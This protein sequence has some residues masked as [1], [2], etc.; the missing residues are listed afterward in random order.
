MGQIWAA[1]HLLLRRRVAV[2]FLSDPL[3]DSLEALQRFSLEAQ[4]IARLASPHVPQVFDYG[5][6]DDGTPFMVMEL[7]QGV[8]L[9]SRLAGDLLSIE[10][11]G[12]MLTQIGSVLS[13]AH[14]IGI[15]HRDIKPENIFL[16]SE[17][18]T[19]TVKLLDFGIAKASTKLDEPVTLHGVTMGTP[20]YMSPEQLLGSRD[21]DGRSDLWS[22]AVVAYNALTG[23]LPFPG[24]TFGAFC[25]AV[26]AGAFAAPSTLRPDLPP[27]LD[28]WFRK[29]LRRSPHDR[30]ASADE[31]VAA[32][33]AA[34]TAAPEA[35]ADAGEGVVPP[36][37]DEPRDAVL[38][39][40]SEVD[41]P[42]PP[43]APAGRSGHGRRGLGLVVTL[44]VIGSAIAFGTGSV[45][46]ALSGPVQSVEVDV[47]RFKA[48]GVSISEALAGD[49][50]R[51]GGAA[52]AAASSVEAPPVQAA[53]AS[54]EAWLSAQ[55]AD[56][57]PS[58]STHEGR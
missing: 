27:A 5:N 49:L 35:T 15:V 40:G 13:A 1:E 10:E 58:K 26:Q 33:S 50:A 44:L 51:A 42:I 23:A 43:M 22:L 28:G 36:R 19:F 31:M 45:P 54:A 48:A 30:F 16:V 29:A 38:S 6:M 12:R 9:Q 39:R 2:K 41:L 47:A 17:E 53:A 4:T 11:T 14:A 18:A 24:D 55:R 37:P 25:F 3:A 8:D 57:A 56:G 32:F 21:L 7:L 34:V 52:P 20:C 46:E